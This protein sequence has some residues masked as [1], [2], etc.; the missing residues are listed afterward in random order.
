MP[1]SIREV[2]A[3]IGTAAHTAFTAANNAAWAAGTAYVL[4][5]TSIDLSKLVHQ[6]IENK[7]LQ[8]RMY[9]GPASKAGLSNSEI[10]LS[11]PL[12]MGSANTTAPFEATLLSAFF[13]GL[14]SP[15]AKTDLCE[16]DCTATLLKATGHGMSAGMAVLVGAPG[17]G[18]GNG[19]VRRIASVTTDEIT[20][21]MALSAAPN[22]GDAL[23]YSHTVYLDQSA[24]QSYLD[25]LVIGYHA[26]DQI[27][28]LR[29]MGPVTFS[30]L[31]EGEEPSM[32]LALQVPQWQEVPAADRDQLEPSV[33]FSGSGQAPTSKA[34]GGCFFGDAGSTTRAAIEAADWA[35]NPG[36]SFV[37]RKDP[38]YENRMGACKRAPGRVTAEITVY[39]DLD[40]GL[41]ADFPSTAKQLTMQFGNTAQACVAITAPKLYLSQK[42]TRASINNMQ[43][44]KLTMHG[45]EPTVA[46]PAVNLFSSALAV[47]WF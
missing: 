21:E 28:A 3:L 47:H 44:L 7:T 8:R 15:T 9:A 42:P 11:L 24:T 30:G 4:P 14:A 46:S 16:A 2:R 13:G 41:H 31:G 23:V 45:D 32:S 17:D 34:L 37:Y 43:G 26:E 36:L 22:T 5:V 1:E 35:V 18:R 12:G 27:Q 25:L 40:Y 39:V 38:N 20:L 19:E 6:G 10:S 29:C 33:A